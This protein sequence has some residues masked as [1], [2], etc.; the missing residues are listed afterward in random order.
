MPS[1]WIGPRLASLRDLFKTVI[2][3]RSFAL[4]LRPK[5]IT[6]MTPFFDTAGPLI[7]SIGSN[8]VPSCIGV[9]APVFLS[10]AWTS[11]RLLLPTTTNLPLASVCT[12]YER[13]SSGAKALGEESGSVR[14]P[15]LPTTKE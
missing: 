11:M 5:G 12:L 9:T 2:I 6:A 15:F 13:P 10:S 8:C 1:V 3:R 4:W 7:P 14:A